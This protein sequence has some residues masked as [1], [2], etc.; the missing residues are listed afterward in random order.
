MKFST[1]PLIFI[2]KWL[3]RI[4]MGLGFLFGSLLLPAFAA[5]ALTGAAEAYQMT[6]TTFILI[7]V[8]WIIEILCLIY[9]VYGI[10]HT[11]RNMGDY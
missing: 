1:A 6:K 4:I 7:G 8:F 9:V 3:S 11:P 5:M 2:G 10:D